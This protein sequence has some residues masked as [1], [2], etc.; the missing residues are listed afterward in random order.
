MKPTLFVI[1]NNSVVSTNQLYVKTSNLWPTPLPKSKHAVLE[2]RTTSHKSFLLPRL[3]GG[4]SPMFAHTQFTMFWV[5][6]G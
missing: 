4:V 1:L 2:P 3:M 5:T 6:N